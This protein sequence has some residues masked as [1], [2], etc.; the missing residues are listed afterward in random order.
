MMNCSESA[1]LYHHLKK[2]CPHQWDTLR[3]GWGVCQ[4]THV[5]KDIGEGCKFTDGLGSLVHLSIDVGKV[6]YQIWY[7][8]ETARVPFQP[9]HY[10]A[11]L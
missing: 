5:E 7:F 1:L 9:G 3:R 2:L 6:L 10:L 4:V 8:S 11:I